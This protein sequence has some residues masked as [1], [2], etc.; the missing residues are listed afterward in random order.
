M[1]YSIKFQKVSYKLNKKSKVFYPVEATVAQLVEQL[2]CNQ[3]VGGSNPFGG[4]ISDMAGVSS[5]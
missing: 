4:S 5:K 3:R 1:S 2:I